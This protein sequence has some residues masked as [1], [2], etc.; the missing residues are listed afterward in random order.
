MQ[1]KLG[2]PF[3]VSVIQR[4]CE[5]SFYSHRG[6]LCIYKHGNHLCLGSHLL[7]WVFYRNQVRHNIECPSSESPIRQPVS[8][9]TAY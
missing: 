1:S 5:Q 2:T 6:D 9:I 8:E 3:P 4:C 7:Q